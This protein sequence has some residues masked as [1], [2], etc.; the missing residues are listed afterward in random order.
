[1]RYLTHDAED[2]FWE[3][4]G[5]KP[6]PLAEKEKKSKRMDPPISH[7]S[8]TSC[9]RPLSNGAPPGEFKEQNRSDSSSTLRSEED[10]PPSQRRDTMTM[11]DEEVMVSEQHA[12]RV[13]YKVSTV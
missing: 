1:M 5:A 6:H 3:A 11:S 13:G 7:G 12:Q 9:P 4:Q 2:T 8:P 10:T